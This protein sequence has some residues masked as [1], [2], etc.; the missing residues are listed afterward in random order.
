VETVTVVASRQS[1]LSEMEMVIGSA[2][3]IALLAW[4]VLSRMR[5]GSQQPHA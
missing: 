3:V 1:G 5:R 4:A 2:L